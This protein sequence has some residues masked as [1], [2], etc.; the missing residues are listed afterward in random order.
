MIWR[1]ASNTKNAYPKFAASLHDI[2]LIPH[3]PEESLPVE[4]P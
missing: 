2:E 1:F 3:I 4:K